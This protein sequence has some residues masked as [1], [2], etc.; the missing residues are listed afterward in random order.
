MKEENNVRIEIKGIIQALENLKTQKHKEDEEIVLFTDC[1]SVIN[2]L[3][4][5]AYL[6]ANSYFSKKNK[7]IL[8]NADIYREF[9]ILFD[10]IKPKLI[11]IKGHAPKSEHNTIQKNFSYIDRLVRKELRK[12]LAQQAETL[13]DSKV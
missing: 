13:Q 11:W 1:I 4:R 3:G 6:E 5:R 10:L 8:A 2:L 12:T 7:G 9:F